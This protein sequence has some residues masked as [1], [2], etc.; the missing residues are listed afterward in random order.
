MRFL[1]F[2]CLGRKSYELIGQPD[3]SAYIVLRFVEKVIE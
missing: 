1:S 2:I 3:T